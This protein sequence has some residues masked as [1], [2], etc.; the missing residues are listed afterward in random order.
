ME[1]SEETLARERE[2]LLALTILGSRPAPPPEVPAP[3]IVVAEAS[4]LNTLWDEVGILGALLGHRPSYSK[5]NLG[6][7]EMTRLEMR[8]HLETVGT[9][10]QYQAFIVTFT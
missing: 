1:P 4:L 9:T 3:A 8:R 7:S 6:S 2:R 10:T 5:P